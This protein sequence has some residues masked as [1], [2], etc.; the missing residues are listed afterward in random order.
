MTKVELLEKLK[1]FTEET[2]KDLMLKTAPQKDD[3]GKEYRAAE[4]FRARLPDSS[5]AKKKAPYILHQIVTSKDIFPPGKRSE[6]VAV[7]RTIFCVYDSDE[8]EGGLALLNLMERLRIALLRQ[9][10]IGKQFKLD[11]EIG[12]E[13]LVYPEPSAPYYLGETLSVW[14]LPV[15]EREVNH[16]EKGHGNFESHSIGT[17]R[18]RP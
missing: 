13:S 8:Q 6:S 3:K 12:L 10:V 17:G 15:V 9:Q 7:V 2:V 5:A 18:S 16:V 11:L 4:V 1:E 14:K